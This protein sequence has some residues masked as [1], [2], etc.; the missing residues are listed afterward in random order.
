M[1]P[2]LPAEFYQLQAEIKM[3]LEQASNDGC[4][5]QPIRAITPLYECRKPDALGVASINGGQ[6]VQTWAEP[7]QFERDDHA[8]F[9]FAIGVSYLPKKPPSLIFY[10]F[11]RFFRD[12]R[13]WQA[14]L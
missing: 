6:H 13:G 3:A 2:E 12:R 14:H 9:N 1:A 4:L 11:N 8:R 10:H 5:K 7:H